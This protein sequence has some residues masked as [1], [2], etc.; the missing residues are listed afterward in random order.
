MLIVLELEF[1]ESLHFRKGI[2]GGSQTQSLE[3]V[4]VSRLGAVAHAL[5]EV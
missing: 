1:M 4:D 2:T 3:V 5:I